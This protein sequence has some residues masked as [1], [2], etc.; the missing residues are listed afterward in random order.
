M[1]NPFRS[2]AEAFQFLLLTVVAF[3]AIALASL[4]GGAWAGVPTW[5]A[6]TGA[7]VFFYLRRGRGE[8]VVRTAPAHIGAEDEQRILVVANE[9]LAEEGLAEAIERAAAGQRRQVWV[10]CPV[11]T[12]R[13]HRWVSDVD[14]ARAEAQERLDETLS[15][16]HAA[17]IEAR[18]EIGD[19]DPLRA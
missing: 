13:V 9:T 2:E 7:T 1:R 12:S 11:L 17:G 18:G 3:A 5:A 16:L 19:E 15:R 6:V 4:L 8:R 14:S 10:V